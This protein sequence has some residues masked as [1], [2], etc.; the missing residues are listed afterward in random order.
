ML[1]GKHVPQT[2]IQPLPHHGEQGPGLQKQAPF[3]PAGFP[4]VLF[5]PSHKMN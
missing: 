4:L 2:L 3:F 1:A 5:S